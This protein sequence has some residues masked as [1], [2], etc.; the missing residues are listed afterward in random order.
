MAKLNNQTI[1][2][3]ELQEKLGEGGFG[4]VYRAYQPVVEREVAVKFILPEYAN[5]PKF[6]QNFEAEAQLIARLEHPHIVPLYDFWRDPDGAYLVMRYLRGGSLRHVLQQQQGL[7]P[8]KILQVMEHVIASLN[9]AHR[10]EV[11]HR[12]IKP[13]NILLD[14]DGNAYLTDFGI[15]KAAGQPSTHQNF[16]GTLAYVSPEQLLG[17]KPAIAMDVYSLGI[18][19]FEIVTGKHPFPNSD[20]IA[21]IYHHTY[22]MPPEVQTINPSAATGFDVIVQRAAAKNAAHRYPDVGE[23][24]RDIQTLVTGK[25]AHSGIISVIASNISNPY[26]GLRAFQEADAADFFGREALI[27][28]LRER[29]QEQHF[30]A[31]VGPSGSGKSSVVRAGLIPRIRMGTLASGEVCFVANFM[32]GVNPL[33]A[34][35]NALIKVSP[36]SLPNLQEQLQSSERGLI[37]AV[38]TILQ[39]TKGSLLL[40]IDQ[41]EEIFLQLEDESQRE[42]F[43]NLLYHAAIEKDSPLRIILTMRADFYDRPLLYEGFGS[44]IE[45]HTQLV[46]PLNAEEIERAIVAPAQRVGLGVEM[47]LL[48]AM[49]ADVRQEPGALPLLQYTLTELFERRNGNM[50]THQAYIESGGILGTIAKRAETTFAALDE[51]KQDITR[52]VFLHLVTPGEG[53]DDTRRRT[54]RAEL[55]DTIFPRDALEDVLTQFGDARLL[56]FD[57]AGT[58]REPMVEVAHEALIREWRRLQIWLDSSR[59][60]IRLHRLLNADLTE[61]DKHNQDESFLLSGGRLEQFAEWVHGSDIA[62]T[63]DEQAFLDASLQKQNEEIARAKAQQARE[64]ELREKSINRLRLLIAAVVAIA[65]MGVILSALSFVGFRTARTAEETAIANGERAQDAEG[66]AVANQERAQDA[67][68]IAIQRANEADARVLASR[69][70]RIALSDPA[71]AYGLALALLEEIENPS[72][73]VRSVVTD[74]LQTNG[75]IRLYEGHQGGVTQVAYSPD[76][77][78]VMSVSQDSTMKLWDV[79][80]GEVLRTYEGHEQWVRGVV[81]LPNGERVITASNDGT[82]KLWDVE[83]GAVLRTYEGHEASVTSVVLAP[84]GLQV[85]SGSVDMTA[86]IWDIES[87]DIVQRLV[88]HEGWIWDVAYAPDGTS[89]ATASEDGNINIW[90]VTSG[91]IVMTLEDSETAVTTIAYAPDK[92][93]LFS[94]NWRGHTIRWDLESGEMIERRLAHDTTIWSVSYS[95]DGQ[96]ALSTSEDGVINLWDM[97]LG[98]SRFSFD[99]HVL[100]ATSAVFAKDNRTAISASEDGT[101]I[102]WDTELVEQQNTYNGHDFIGSGLALSSDGQ[103]L[104]TS[105][106]DETVILWD[107]ESQNILRTLERHD[108]W[109]TGVAYA[110]DDRTVISGDWDGNLIQWDVETGNMLQRIEAHDAR[111]EDLEYSPDSRLAI[112]ASIDGTAKV[113]DLSDGSLLQTFDQHDVEVSSVTFSPDGEAALS[114]AAGGVMLMWDIDSGDILH[115]YMGHRGTIM[116]IKFSPDGQSI[117]TASTDSRLILWDAQSADIQRTFV[118]HSRLVEVVSF[119]PDGRTALSSSADATIILWDIQTGE[120]LRTFDQGA[121]VSAV[122]FEPNGL[123]AIGMSGKGFAERWEIFSPIEDLIRWTRERRVVRAL[124]CADRDLY[125]TPFRCAANSGD[126]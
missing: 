77:S 10:H 52:Q 78:Q 82:L 39:N 62:I 97:E 64:I 100:A 34:L 88:G 56:T 113:W 86:I 40:V 61:W 63:P 116:D 11:V 45:Q 21:M 103:T 87:G 55:Y 6:I 5:K 43:L 28:A 8:R 13:D 74:F 93:V 57:I 12:D 84:N 115:T 54:R 27:N 106:W 98:I 7:E 96:F 79:A 108:A 126:L 66:T 35:E 81:W 122:A 48:A 112:T 69:L 9:V 1:R 15:A 3:Y 17:E 85:V 4:I 58:H 47:P 105:S 76:E 50:L 109:V 71:L 30:V 37:W 67:E 38:N 101:L 114:G 24:L 92:P 94:G 42:H 33:Q 60:D 95:A 36:V 29:L 19:L 89:I 44:L 111:I 41:F 26:K 120:I 70:P 51:A 75:A 72:L 90:D 110:P 118:G 53:S 107:V 121:W 25:A 83:T 91:E 59:N 73:I 80:T 31:V 32:P 68:E 102:R 123:M 104:A 23:L 117:L 125:C 65:V 46:L 22:D 119:A 16:S 99:G 124:T 18:M 2:G 14:E 20:T 49:V